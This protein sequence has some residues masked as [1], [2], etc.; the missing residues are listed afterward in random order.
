MRIEQSVWK[1][2]EKR[3]QFLKRSRSELKASKGRFK[4][5]KRTTVQMRVEKD[6]Y[7]RV[8]MIAKLEKRTIS[9]IASSIL[10]SVC[11]D[12]IDG[13]IELYKDLLPS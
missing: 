2:D 9:H 7:Q 11:H 8:K 3:V 5:K 1:K 6:V 10:A 13:Q 12:L 4:R